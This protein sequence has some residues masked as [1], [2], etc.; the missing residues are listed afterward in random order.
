MESHRW[1][2]PMRVKRQMEILSEGK[3]KV[4]IWS[5]SQSNSAS[6]LSA[7]EQQNFCLRSVRGRRRTAFVR[8]IIQDATA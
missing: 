4:S 2:R 7:A 1:R 8:G 5:W 6:E 3:F